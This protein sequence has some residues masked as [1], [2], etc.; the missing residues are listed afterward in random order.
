[1]NDA[2][3]L[4]EAP[5][6]AT[7]PPRILVVDDTESVLVVATAFLE[8]DGYDVVTA[9][10][11]ADAI[12]ILKQDSFAV[13]VSDVKMPQMT[14]MQFLAQAKLLQPDASRILM[15]AYVELDAILEAINRGEIYRFISKPFVRAEFLATVKT[16]VQRYT[17]I[18]QNQGLHQ[19]TQTM[20]R[21][22]AET[23]RILH[24]QMARVADQNIQLESLNKSLDH[25][26]EGIV[27]LCFKQVETFYPILGRNARRAHAMCDAM[28]AVLNLPEDDKR[29]L[30]IASWLYDI[31]LVGV[32]RPL[33][34][35]WWDH[36]NSLGETERELI[37]Q[38]PI[39]GQELTS[40]VQQFGKVG[41]MIRAHHERFDGQ[42]Y[43]DGLEGEQISWLNQL[44][45][46]A[47]GYA[48]AV[49]RR[50]D[51]TERLKAGSGTEFDPEAV[52]LLVRCLPHVPSTRGEREVLLRELEP[53]MVLAKAIHNANGM[54]LLPESQVLTAAWINKLHAHNRVTLISETLAVRV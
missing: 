14:G 1:M 42:G 12:E 47:V 15:T 40:F 9:S 39:L 29:M 43:P 33:F 32:P 19:A 2:T 13:I 53:G 45:A 54:L 49:E 4:L 18:Q 20:N 7:R 10:N 34:Q 22:L 23:N 41:A 6:I 27:E 48:E 11:G 37:Q 26:L 51:P 16:A 5:S 35:R 28:A 30:G 38:H 31:G 46:V 17:L 36:P 44:L 24:E 52:R 21:Q 3:A 8:P 25:M 50:Q